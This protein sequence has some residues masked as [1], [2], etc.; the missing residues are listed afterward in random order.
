MILHTVYT[1][2]LH[3]TQY[4]MQPILEMYNVENT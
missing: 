2:T 1:C 4:N 3:I